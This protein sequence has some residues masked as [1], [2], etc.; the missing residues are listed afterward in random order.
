MTKQFKLILCL[1]IA[2]H[3]PTFAAQKT[4]TMGMGISS[5]DS[6]F[7]QSAAYHL[8]LHQTFPNGFG[9][10]FGIGMIEAKSDTLTSNKIVPVSTQVTYTFSHQDT[11]SAYVGGGFAMLI[12]SESYEQ[13]NPSV[14]ASAGASYKLDPITEFRL[15]LEK[16]FSTDDTRSME[17]NPLTVRLGVG[18]NF[19]HPRR[20]KKNKNKSKNKGLK[21]RRRRGQRPGQQGRSRPRQPLS[22]ERAAIMLQNQQTAQKIQS[23]YSPDNVVNKMSWN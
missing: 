22:R 14:I 16:I 6:N 15:D 8:G 13:T 5:F 11:L 19:H 7:K 21:N 4:I 9:L 20:M 10:A 17:I 2:L 18:L 1:L 3:I 12:Q 23:Q